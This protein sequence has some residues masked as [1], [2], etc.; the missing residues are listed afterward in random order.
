MDRGR[1]RQ[2]RPR[3]CGQGRAEDRQPQAQQPPAGAAPARELRQPAP[4]AR[5]ARH[6]QPAPHRGGRARL[7]PERTAGHLRA[8][9]PVDAG[10]PPGQPRLQGRR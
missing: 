4:G 10:G 2:P 8:G 3:R 5:M 6:P 7:A 9:A 1:S